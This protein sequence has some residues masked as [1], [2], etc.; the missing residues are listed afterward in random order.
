[1]ALSRLEWVGVVSEAGPNPGKATR[2][3]AWLL[4]EQLLSP[5]NAGAVYLGRATTAP[6]EGAR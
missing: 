4:W 5:F 3:L 6:A 2:V 1:M